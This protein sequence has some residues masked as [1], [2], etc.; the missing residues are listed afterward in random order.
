MIPLSD[1]L[2]FK[3]KAIIQGFGY[4][5]LPN[6]N[7]ELIMEV[8]I[9]DQSGKLIINNN[10]NQKREVRYYL[11]NDKRVDAQFNPVES[12]G[13]GEFDY[14]FNLLDEIPLTSLVIQLATKLNERGIFD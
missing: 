5:S 2:T 7:I 1:F 11:T 10:I 3:R 14:F 9:T 8:Q 12:G 13:T 4:F 6:Q